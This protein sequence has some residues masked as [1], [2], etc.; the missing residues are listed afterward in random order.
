MTYF[1]PYVDASGLHLPTYD[2]ILQKRIEDAKAIYGQDIYLAN[3]SLDY[4]MIS[5][6]SLALYDVMQAIQYAYNQASPLTAVG[7][8]LSSLVQLNG[9]TRSAATHSTCDV[10][11]VGSSAIT[12]TNGQVKD[13]A[14]NIWDLPTPITLQA[15]GSP[16]GVSYMLTVTATCQTPG[17]VVALVDDINIIVSPRAGWISVT[18]LSPAAVGQDAES[19]SDLRERQALS[20]ELPSQTMLSGTLAAIAAVMNVTR[21]AVYENPSNSTHYGDPGVPFE[22]APEHSITCIVEGGDIEDIAE[23]IYYNKGLGCYTNGDVETVITDE[24]YGSITP[25]R[26]YRPEYVDVY[27]EITLHQMTG[28]TVDVPLLIKAAVAEFINDLGIG[29][30]LT[31]SSIIGV[32]MGLNTNPLKPIFSITSVLIGKSP[33]PALSTAD[34]DLDYKEVFLGDILNIEV[35]ET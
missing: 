5:V 9:L 7:V 35:V 17:A 10:T 32:V 25:I 15:V 2:D 3:D 30:I 22:G 27:V 19:D 34:L 12:I 8:G 14:G 16:P 6:E 20:V 24:E 31:V 23:A 4:Q 1:A 11:L 26:F 18:N 21:Y 33:S 29:D 28:Y 13:Q